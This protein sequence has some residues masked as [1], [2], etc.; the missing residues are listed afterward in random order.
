MMPS[1]LAAIPLSRN[2]SNEHRLETGEYCQRI[3]EALYREIAK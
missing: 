1:I 2:H 3:A